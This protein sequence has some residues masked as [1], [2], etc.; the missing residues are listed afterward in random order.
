[1][2][3]LSNEKSYRLWILN[4]GKAAS[5]GNFKLKTNKSYYPF[6]LPEQNFKGEIRFLVTEEASD[7]TARPSNKVDLSGILQ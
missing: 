4:G 7:S 3:E 6:I 5:L 1:M 2:P